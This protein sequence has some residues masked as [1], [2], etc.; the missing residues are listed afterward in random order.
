[1][2]GKSPATDFVYEQKPICRH[3]KPQNL[4]EYLIRATIPYQEGDGK[5]QQDLLRKEYN[6]SQEALWVPEVAADW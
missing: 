2:L 3:R 1:M 6:V 5:T 4:S